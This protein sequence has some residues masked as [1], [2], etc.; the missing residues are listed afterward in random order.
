MPKFGSLIQHLRAEHVD[1]LVRLARITIEVKKLADYHRGVRTRP[2]RLFKLVEHRLGAPLR[3]AKRA[4]GTG[5]ACCS[6]AM[7]FIFCLVAGRLGELRSLALVADASSSGREAL[8]REVS[9]AWR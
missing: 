5:P 3:I 1:G 6:T 4:K 9:A 2:V 8:A 7:S